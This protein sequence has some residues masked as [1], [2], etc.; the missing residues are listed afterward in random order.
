MSYLSETATLEYETSGNNGSTSY[1]Y[2]LPHTKTIDLIGEEFAPKRSQQ[3]PN[4][5]S[6]QPSVI[7]EAI[8]GSAVSA[9]HHSVNSVADISVPVSTMSQQLGPNVVFVNTSGSSGVPLQ[10]QQIIQQAQQ[11]GHLQG[12]SQTI[13]LSSLPQSSI[14]TSSGSNTILIQ[15]DQASQS[16]TNLPLTPVTVDL[17]SIGAQSTNEES[18]VLLCNLDDL[19]KYIPENFYSDFTM[20]DQSVGVSD[21]LQTVVAGKSNTTTVSASSNGSTMNLQQAPS[22]IQLPISMT[23]TVAAGQSI[24]AAGQPAQGQHAHGQV[25]TQHQPIT[26]QLPTQPQPVQGV[27]TVTYVNPVISKANSQATVTTSSASLQP[28]RVTQY[29]YTQTGERIAIQGLTPDQVKPG[30]TVQ[31]QVKGGGTQTLQLQSLQGLTVDPSK[32]TVLQELPEVGKVVIQEARSMGSDSITSILEEMKTENTDTI[33][34][35]HGSMEYATAIPV[36]VTPLASDPKKTTIKRVAA[37]ASTVFLPGNKTSRNIIFAGNT[38][39]QGAIPI[40]I[41]GL[42]AIPLS[43]VKSLPIGISTINTAG[44]QTVAKRT[45]VE[46]IP[47]NAMTKTVTSSLPMVTKVAATNNN[48]P[49]TQINVAGG[50]SLTSTVRPVTSVT[51]QNLT[52][53]VGNNK[54]CNWVFE[55]G[56]VCGKTFAKSYN[57]VVHMRMHEDVRPFGCSFC[58]QTF[59]QKAHLQRHETTHGVGVKVSRGSSSTSRRKRKRSRAA[60]NS[61]GAAQGTSTTTTTTIIQT[62][63]APSTQP[64]VLS[65]N[66]QQRLARVSEQFTTTATGSGTTYVTTKAEP[67]EED[68]DEELAVNH[69]DGPLKSYSKRKNSSDDKSEDD[70]DEDGLRESKTTVTIQ[71]DPTDTTNFQRSQYEVTE[72]REEDIIE[73]VPGTTVVMTSAGAVV[74]NT[75]STTTSSVHDA[76]AAAVNEAI[77]DMEYHSEAAEVAAAEVV[78]NNVRVEAQPVA[79]H[80]NM[81]PETLTAISGGSSPQS[82]NHGT[83]GNRD[84]SSNMQDIFTGGNTKHN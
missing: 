27:K 12:N 16:G 36:A 39:P 11:Q 24:S 54:T 30:S 61:G 47:A 57:L 22:T 65:T 26:I 2:H 42:N 62:Q 5:L 9:D 52:R 28:L 78:E 29:A 33:T 19:S 43:A 38:L 37:P 71:L 10:V 25:S 32:L 15:P 79:T 74:T 66:L 70:M 34:L 49:K 18:G 46:I 82:G 21:Y 55:N 58:D 53:T 3:Q 50:S 72:L 83:S 13:T 44:V 64:T 20:A 40:Q 35:P 68:E 60:S 23:Q 6:N 8:G 45:K 51:Q 1:E 69:G 76:V 14:V 7:V 59:R 41:N 75:G 80:S 67:E 77:K 31:L 84:E 63:Q 48:A 73:A 81:S 56:E 4:H 17:P